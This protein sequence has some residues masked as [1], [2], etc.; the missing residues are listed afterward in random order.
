MYLR[1]MPGPSFLASLSVHPCTWLM[2]LC[3]IFNVSEGLASS[4]GQERG[5]G[6]HLV[7]LSNTSDSL[8]ITEIFRD[9]YSGKV[10][11]NGIGHFW[12]HLLQLALNEFWGLPDLAGKWERADDH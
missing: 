8:S 7:C 3:E 1:S 10:L 9:V 12:C 2:W 11:V 4:L 5:A 6:N